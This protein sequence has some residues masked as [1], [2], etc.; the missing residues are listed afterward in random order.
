MG[1]DIKLD[2]NYPE[3]I[4][5]EEGVTMTTRCIIVTHFMEIDDKY[6][7]S[8]FTGK[9]DHKEAGLHWSKHGDM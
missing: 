2:T 3:D 1:E 5:I 9:S 6:E 8:L 4:I 7:S